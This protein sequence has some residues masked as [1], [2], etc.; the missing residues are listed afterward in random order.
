MRTV[1]R[2]VAVAAIAVALVGC[3]TFPT[4]GWSTAPSPDATTAAAPASSQPSP[5][6][7]VGASGGAIEITAFD[8]GF[9][10]AA[11]TVPAAG[12]YD[13]TF[14]NTGA[15]PHDVTF[16]DGTKIAADPGKSATGTVTVPADGIAFIC[17]IPGHEAAGMKGAVAVAGTAAASPAASPSGD[18]HG[19]PLPAGDVAADPNAPAYEPIDATAPALLPG[20]S[21]D[22]DLVIT[23][24]EKTIAPGFVQK[25]WT[26]GGTVPGPV[27][28][29]KV[30]DT[31]RV[32]LKNPASEPAV[33]FHRLPRQPGRLE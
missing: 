22:I 9:T 28:R 8:L 21:H 25:V 14:D 33:A 1:L 20:T 7:D 23:E 4:G 27:I 5:T 30:G 12:T 13:V 29:V 16:A 2:L 32:H 17:S 15:S 24:E 11:V 3:T 10:P 31:I 18:S 26:F 19:G 6:A